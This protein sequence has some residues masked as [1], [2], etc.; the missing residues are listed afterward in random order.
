MRRP[1]QISC[2]A[3]L[4]NE[5]K[6]DSAL[7]CSS[8]SKTSNASGSLKP[9]KYKKFLFW[10]KAYSV[11]L[12]RVSSLA[13]G[14]KAIELFGILAISAARCSVKSLKGNW[15]IGALFNGEVLM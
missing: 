1:C 15:L 12:L 2:K 4:A 9:V 14:N 6:I 3:S 7:P 8:L 13:P 5:N 11:S 10:Q